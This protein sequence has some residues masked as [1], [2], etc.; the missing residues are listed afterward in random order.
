MELLL[1]ERARQK[2]RKIGI[3]VTSLTDSLIAGLRKA[4]KFCEP[5][6]Y[7]TNVQGFTSIVSAKPEDALFSDLER[8][9]IDGCSRGQIHAIPFRE[10]FIQSYDKSFSPIEE[11]ITVLEFPNGKPLLVSP[12]SNINLANIE[13]KEK[14]IN[15]SIRFCK[16]IGL[17][18]KIGLLTQCR[19]EDL[20]AVSATSLEQNYRDTEKLF[21]IY[22]YSFEIKNY[23]ID[24]EKAYEDNVTI[25]IEPNGTSG[26]QV[27]RTLYFLNVVR[28]YGAPYMNAKHIV[29]ESFKNSKDFPDVMMLAAALANSKI[30]I[31]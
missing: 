3:G 18:I 6:I 28:F 2:R 24:F 13:E 21:E 4:D 11:M 31:G 22:R 16:L 7:G 9:A 14:L 25:L 5:V 8:G 30:N 20:E 15:A 1:I 27:I 26:N 23:G 29:V 17:P 12:G 19:K 10:R